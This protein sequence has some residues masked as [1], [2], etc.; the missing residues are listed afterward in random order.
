M[1]DIFF[2][3]GNIVLNKIN[4]DVCGGRGKIIKYFVEILS[5][6]KRDDI[7]KIGCRVGE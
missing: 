1:V 5:F 3:D 6:F 7:D 2:I 4:I